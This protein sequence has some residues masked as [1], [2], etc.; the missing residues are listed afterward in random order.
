MAEYQFPTVFPHGDIDELFADIFFVTGSVS[1]S[2]P[3]P[4][5]FSRNMVIVRQGES[6]TL[7]NSLRLDEARLAKLDALGKVENV[8]RLAGFH[9]MDDPFYKDRYGAKIWAVKGQVYAPGVTNAET[10]PKDG[11][12]QADVEMDANTELPIAGATLTTFNCKAGEGILRLDREGGILV[13]GDSLQNW[14]S[15]EYFNLPASLMMR[16]MGFIK[17]HNIGPGWLKAAKPDI[18]EVKAILDL[19]FEHLLPVHGTPVK[20]DA[21]NKYR[22]VIQKL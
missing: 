12:F 5:R 11:Y 1:M 16:L 10:A 4:L 14:I 21:K 20:G 15:T 13:C 22:P 3:L 18:A 7:I 6:L 17:P 19:E 9:G 8:I 2:V